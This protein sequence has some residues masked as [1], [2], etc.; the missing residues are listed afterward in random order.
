MATFKKLVKNLGPDIHDIYLEYILPDFETVNNAFIPS[1]QIIESD[2]CKDC[3]KRLGRF[4]SN[5]N[6]PRCYFDADGMKFRENK[7]LCPDNPDVQIVNIPNELRTFLELPKLQIY[8]SQDDEHEKMWNYIRKH[9]LIRG[10]TILPDKALSD[11]FGISE[12]KPIYQ[13]DIF[14]LLQKLHYKD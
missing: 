12:N 8:L 13:V 4:P 1:L 6:L 7:C 5:K 10:L 2:I 9:G 11:L 14:Y 3:Y